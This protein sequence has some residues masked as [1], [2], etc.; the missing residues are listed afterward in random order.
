MSAFEQ[1]VE[2]AEKTHMYLLFAAVSQRDGGWQGGWGG[3]SWGRVQCAGGGG[4]GG[5][6][7]Q[8][9]HTGLR[10][11]PRWLGVTSAGRRLEPFGSPD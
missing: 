5:G 2:V 6:R 7:R 8:R 3:L 10:R 1:R 4:G 9:K 11:L